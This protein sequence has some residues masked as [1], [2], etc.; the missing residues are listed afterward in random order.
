[1]GEAQKYSNIVIV[2]MC[3][4]CVYRCG[5]CLQIMC[6]HVAV[7]VSIICECGTETCV[8]TQYGT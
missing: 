6:A 1:M 4:N 7:F 8:N 5:G 2:N 3:V